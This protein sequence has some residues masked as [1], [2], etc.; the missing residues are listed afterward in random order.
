MFVVTVGAPTI[1]APEVAMPIADPAIDSGVSKD[2]DV[3]GNFT[4]PDGDD[5]DLTF[6]R[7]E[8]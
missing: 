6:D 5:L 3:S 1:P 4:D 8:R 7:R 2:V